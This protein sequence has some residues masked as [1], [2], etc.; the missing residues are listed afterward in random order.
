MHLAEEVIL[1]SVHFWYFGKQIQVLQN[2][3]N[4]D[5]MFQNH[6]KAH[7]KNEKLKQTSSLFRL[8]LFLDEKGLLR[9][10]GQLQEATLAYEVKHPIVVPEKS[11]ITELLIRQYQSRPT[12]S[13]LRYDTQCT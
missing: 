10:E 9:I 1:K 3:S 13:R 11:H 6:Q 2:L 8:Y 4:K 5:P 7:T 12:S